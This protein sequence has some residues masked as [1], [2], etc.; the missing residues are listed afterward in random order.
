MKLFL[1]F[2]LMPYAVNALL[3]RICTNCE[4]EITGPKFSTCGVDQSCY[5]LNRVNPQMTEMGCGSSCSLL[6]RSRRMEDPCHLCHYDKCN[7]GKK[8]IVRGDSHE[9]VQFNRMRETTPD[10]IHIEEE[11][12][13]LPRDEIVEYV[14]DVNDESPMIKT[15]DIIRL[16][17]TLIDRSKVPP[18]IPVPVDVSLALKKRGEVKLISDGDSAFLDELLEKEIGYDLDTLNAKVDNARAERVLQEEKKIEEEEREKE[19]WETYAGI[20]MTHVDLNNR[21]RYQSATQFNPTHFSLIP[22]TIFIH[23]IV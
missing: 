12:Y 13:P 5:T 4:L 18:L 19:E 23:F 11:I 17:G 7:S 8:I 14:D 1:L 6:E 20:L 22:I 2:S 15:A 9:N 10:I 3:C 21:K 16:N